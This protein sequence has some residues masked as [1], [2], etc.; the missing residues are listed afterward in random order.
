MKP[1]V[2]SVVDVARSLIAIESENPPGNEQACAE[3]VAKW[4][5]D[6]GLTVSLVESPDPTRPSAAA[7]IGS[8]EPTIVLNGHIDVVPA[9]DRDAWSVDPYGGV[10]DG[11]RLYGRGSADMKTGLALGM[12]VA[13]DLAPAVE[14]SGTGSIVVHAAAGEET[15]YPGTKA[16][17]DA[18][19]TGDAAVVLEPT[20]LRVATSAKGVATYRIEV[21]GDPCHA[22][23]PDQGR[24][25][26]DGLDRALGA[27]ETYD[28]VVRERRDP[29][30]GS[31]FATVTE[32][33]AGIDENMAVV[34]GRG[35]LLLD[36]RVL[37]G[38]SIDAIDDEITDLCE[39]AAINGAPCEHTRIQYYAPSKVDPDRPIAR[40]FLE[41]SH[42]LAAVPAEPIGLEAATDAREFAAVG[43]DAIVWGPGRLGQAHTLDEWISL[44]EVATA[45]TVLE[46]ALRQ[47]L[48]IE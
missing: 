12:V 35:H 26:I 4:F 34:P 31:A 15:G 37:P 42:D 8:G 17:L 2:D 48:G 3:Y 43:A 47:F 23:R 39:H 30:C 25:P 20:G 22:S 41:R 5:D 13:R 27:I 7:R 45:Q 18:G 11:D 40:E 38:E 29:L 9:G 32:I 44:K 33:A 1:T 24:N 36:R 16:L 19:F 14:R 28:A 6:C 46:A 10:V 21:S